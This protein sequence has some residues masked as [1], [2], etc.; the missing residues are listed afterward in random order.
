MRWKRD[1]RRSGAGG[2][3]SPPAPTPQKRGHS[4]AA[5][6][7]KKAGSARLRPST[8]GPPPA[9]PRPTGAAKN[10]PPRPNPPTPSHP[11]QKSR[12]CEAPSEH[13][14]SANRN[15]P[16]RWATQPQPTAKPIAHP[17]IDSASPFE[18]TSSADEN[19]SSAHRSAARPRARSGAR[20]EPRTPGTV[21]GQGQKRG[22]SGFRSVPFSRKTR[23][24]PFLGVLFWVSPFGSRL[25]L[26]LVLRHHLPANLG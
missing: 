24:T 16:L 8:A 9:Q 23:M 12:E 17:V 20:T 25:E 11:P 13:R 3:E 4:H 15:Q 1:S 10:V 6:H 14:S 7:P 2:K 19:P 26:D 21:R 5:T 18:G 22:H